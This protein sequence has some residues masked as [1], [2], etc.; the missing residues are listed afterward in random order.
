MLK[1][2]PVPKYPVQDCDVHINN[3]SKILK[4]TRVMN[5]VLHKGECLQLN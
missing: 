4:E 3:C 5:L 2:K 1:R